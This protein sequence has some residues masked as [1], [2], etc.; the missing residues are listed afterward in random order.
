MYF[1]AL[2]F[3]VLMIMIFNAY[4]KR[5]PI[6]R[7]KI[8]HHR[9]FDKDMCE[10]N[11]TLVLKTEIINRSSHS[12]GRIYVKNVMDE[13]FV[14][15]EG[16]KFKEES[17]GERKRVTYRTFVKARNSRVVETRLEPRKR[18]VYKVTDIDVD[19]LDLLGFHNAF[20]KKQDKIKVTVLPK[21]VNNKF[22]SK[23]IEGGYGDFNAKRGFIDD[24]TTIR[25]YGE[26]TGH[27]P[28]RHINWK[29]SAQMDEFVVKQFEPMG[30]HVTTIVL[31]V[32]EVI[33]SKEGSANYLLVEY[34][35]SMLREIFEYF[36]EKRITYRFITNAKSSHL[37]DGVFE[38]K[39]SGKKTKREML[40][41]LGELSYKFNDRQSYCL[42][43]KELL[44]NAISRSY[45]APFLYL[46]TRNTKKITER[47]KKIGKIKGIEITELYSEDYVDLRED[48]RNGA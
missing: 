36:E 3:I 24:E 42:S 6:S 11:E 13:A 32:S 29:K 20:Y 18:G 2:V 7:D 41:M 26:Y 22:L 25:T 44:A 10:Q 23:L 14:L 40:S 17:F 37:V 47:L 43:S 33:N 9:S 12:M 8:S 34:A 28:M 27:E 30:T 19:Y 39:P 35:I 31:D 21:R 38:S 5:D 1:F 45:R 15:K 4:S 16:K 48:V 46:S